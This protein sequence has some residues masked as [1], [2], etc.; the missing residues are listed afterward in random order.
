LTNEREIGKKNAMFSLA[1]IPLLITAFV[2]AAILVTSARADRL[3][4]GDDWGK[5]LY[6]LD[7]NFGGWSK[8]VFSDQ[9]MGVNGLG[10]DGKGNLYEADFGSRAIRKFT[11]DGNHTVFANLDGPGA[12][13]TFDREGN[14]FIPFQWAGRIDKFTPD[15]SQRS[16][17]A[18][19]SPQP[20]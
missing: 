19:D 6:E 8:T 4:T 9:T 3:F 18:T 12:A 15:G 1:K 14:L 20:V 11:P 2:L 10:T 16:V 17:F 5:N 7:T 13:I